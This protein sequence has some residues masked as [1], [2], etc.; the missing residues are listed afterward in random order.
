MGLESPT[1]QEEK[2]KRKMTKKSQKNQG[3]RKRGGLNASWLLVGKK[4]LSSDPKSTQNP[5]NPLQKD[6]NYYY[7]FSQSLY[8]TLILLPF[9]PPPFFPLRLRFISNSLTLPFS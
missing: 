5:P 7:S 4:I 6:L 9:H 2:R 8:L 1:G 3:K